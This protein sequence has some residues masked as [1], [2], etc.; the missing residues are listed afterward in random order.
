[1][2]FLVYRIKAD[3][4]MIS[5]EFKPESLESTRVVRPIGDAD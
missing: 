4:P 1:M 2:L 5:D 3:Y